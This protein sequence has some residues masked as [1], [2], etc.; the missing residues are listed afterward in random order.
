LVVNVRLLPPPGEGGRHHSPGPSGPPP[1]QPGPHVHRHF[2]CHVPHHHPP[3]HCKLLASPAADRGAA[4]G[5]GHVCGSGD[6]GFKAKEFTGGKN[7]GLIAGTDEPGCDVCCCAL[8]VPHHINCCVLLS[9]SRL[10][11]QSPT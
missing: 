2:P 5:D 7:S 6:Y 9:S 8:R 11:V 3:T 10:C 4:W 1:V